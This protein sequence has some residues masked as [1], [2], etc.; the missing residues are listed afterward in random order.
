MQSTV[1]RQCGKPFDIE[2][3]E[4]VNVAESPSFKDA[5]KDGSAFVH[6]CP[7]CDA[8]NLVR[9]RLL[10]HD[11]DEHLMIWLIPEDSFTPEDKSKMEESM[12]TLWTSL[13]EGLPDYI[14][15]RVEDPGSLIEKVRIFDYGLDDAAIEMCK[16]VTRMELSQAEKDPAK[17]DALSEVQLRFRSLEGADNEL[18]FVFPLEGAMHSV[19]AGFNVYEDC[20]AILGRNPELAPDG[21]FPLIDTSWTASHFR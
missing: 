9:F 7:H 18:E 21:P 13:R 17:A 10:Y 6:R 15:R 11:P 2:A 12:K 5:V 14:F 20:R 4:A 19:K 8:V 3:P 1:C 16:H